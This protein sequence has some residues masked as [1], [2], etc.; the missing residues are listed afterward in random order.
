M[1]LYNSFAAPSSVLHS[2]HCCGRGMEATVSLVSCA[3]GKRPWYRCCMPTTETEL[4]TP[5]SLNF[6][7]A[8]VLAMDISMASTHEKGGQCSFS[9][10]IF[11]LIA[12]IK[13][14]PLIASKLKDIGREN[15]QRYVTSIRDAL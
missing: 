7:C 2:G 12:V 1:R 4:S 10:L 14:D 9:I 6:P 11:L 3:I 15:I 5:G 13:T 8:N